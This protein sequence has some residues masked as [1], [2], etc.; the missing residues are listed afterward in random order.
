MSFPDYATTP[1]GFQQI[2]P[3]SFVNASGTALRA[4]IDGALYPQSAGGANGALPPAYYGGVGAIDLQATS[5]D[6]AP[7]DVL[8]YEGVVVATQGASTSTLS[9]TATTIVRAAGDWAADGR[10]IGD[11]VVLMAPSAGPGNAQDGIV[12]SVSAVTATTLTVAGLSVNASLVAGTRMVLVK[13]LGRVTVA[14]GAGTN[15]TAN[16]VDVL[17]TLA[18]YTTL[19]TDRRFGVN[20]ML[21]AGMQAAVTAGLAVSLGGNL[22][23]Y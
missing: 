1:V 11:Q 8:F 13:P 22:S 21:L 4:L 15:G 10:R 3:L 9:T 18:G 20:D 19:K 12:C 6:S 14:A 16:A 7:R 23:R 2:P 17:T 5:T